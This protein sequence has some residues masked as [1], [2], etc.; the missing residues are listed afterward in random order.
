[1][2]EV[3]LMLTVADR[4][5]ERQAGRVPLMGQMILRVC[6]VHGQSD[7]PPLSVS[8]NARQDVVTG[9]ALCETSHQDNHGDKGRERAEATRYSRRRASRHLQ[10]GWNFMALYLSE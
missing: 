9:Y 7:L 10:D 3:F 2:D 4:I 5:L 6:R 8:V 1:M